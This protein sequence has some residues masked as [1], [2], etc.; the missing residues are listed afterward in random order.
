[1][2]TRKDPDHKVVAH[3]RRKFVKAQQAQPKGKPSKK[4]QQVLAWIGSLYALEKQ[5]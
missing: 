4:L 1:M 2:H 3:V 5:W